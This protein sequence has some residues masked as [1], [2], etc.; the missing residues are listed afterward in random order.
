MPRTLSPASA[1]TSA[2]SLLATAARTMAS[3]CVGKARCH[4]GSFLA[5]RWGG[6]W[7]GGQVGWGGAFGYDGTVKAVG[8]GLV[9]GGGRTLQLRGVNFGAV[10]D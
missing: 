10:H 4:S 6:S 8:S 5:W 1:D 9:N 3:Q 7:W 2:V